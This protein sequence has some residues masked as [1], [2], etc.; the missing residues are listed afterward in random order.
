MIKTSD[1]HGHKFFINLCGHHEVAM[2][3]NLVQWVGQYLEHLLQQAHLVLRNSINIYENEYKINRIH[4]FMTNLLCHDL[5]HMIYYY[6]LWPTSKNSIFF[7]LQRVKCKTYLSFNW[8]WWPLSRCLSLGPK[9]DKPDEDSNS[10][11]ISTNWFGTAIL[12]TRLVKWHI[13]QH[14]FHCISR[15]L[16]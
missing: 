10:G 11:S 13:V 7:G 14:T 12:L 1:G 6:H 8:K 2:P 5:R 9:L 4:L 16:P 3:K 15:H